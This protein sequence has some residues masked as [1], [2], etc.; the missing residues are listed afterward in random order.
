M[1]APP[2]LPCLPFSSCAGSAEPSYPCGWFIRHSFGCLTHNHMTRRGPSCIAP[3]CGIMCASLYVLIFLSLDAVGFRAAPW[4]SREG[5]RSRDACVRMASR[6]GKG[7]PRGKEQEAANRINLA[8]P[9]SRKDILHSVSLVARKF[10][11]C[12]FS[13]LH[14]IWGH[15]QTC[16]HVLQSSGS[17]GGGRI[18]TPLRACR[19]RSLTTVPRIYSPLSYVL[20][21]LWCCL[22]DCSGVLRGAGVHRTRVCPVARVPS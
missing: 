10:R 18:R 2:H 3:K 7:E 6:R 19:T 13:L 8:A 16:K 14:D 11:C 12:Y 20:P 4:V 1:F 22:C 9:C 5:T 15:V 21:Y 17:T